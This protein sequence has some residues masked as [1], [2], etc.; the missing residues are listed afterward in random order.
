MTSLVPVLLPA[1]M[2]WTRAL[3]PAPEPFGRCTAW[4]PARNTTLGSTRRES[5]YW[6]PSRSRCRRYYQCRGC[7]SGRDGPVHPVGEAGVEVDGGVEVDHLVL[8]ADLVVARYHRRR[9]RQRR[10][11]IT[12]CSVSDPTP[13]TSPLDGA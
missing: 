10:K 5:R 12:Y 4:V 3:K 8:V 6:C 2:S 1:S 13:T 11:S 7:T 9:P